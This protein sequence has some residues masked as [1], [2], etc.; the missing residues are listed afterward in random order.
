MLIQ[1]ELFA[2]LGV[3]FGS[4]KVERGLRNEAFYVPTLH[5]IS[6]FKKVSCHD[7]RRSWMITLFLQVNPVHK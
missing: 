5:M 4:P 2:N 3:V 6:P 1:H 7:F